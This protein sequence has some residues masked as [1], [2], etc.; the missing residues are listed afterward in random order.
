MNSKIFKQVESFAKNMMD[1]AGRDDEKSFYDFYN[2]LKCLCDEN[3]GKKNDH[4]VLWE[5]LADFTDDCEES[6]LFYKQAYQIADKLKENEYKASIQ[7]S[8]AQRYME[9]SQSLEAKGSL[10]KAEKFASYTEDE[11]LKREIAEML[12]KLD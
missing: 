5:T 6:I 11:E 12:K 10:L 7:F 8:L 2:Q 9:L 1:A 4:P 3:N